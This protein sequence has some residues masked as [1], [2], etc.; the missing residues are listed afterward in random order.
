[1][2]NVNWSEVDTNNVE[3]NWNYKIDKIH[4]G[5]EINIPKIKITNTKKKK[6]LT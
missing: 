4:E 6:G 2:G 1:M 3:A 5:I